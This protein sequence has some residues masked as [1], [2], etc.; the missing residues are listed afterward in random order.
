MNN[1]LTIKINLDK[2]TTEDLSFRYI[3]ADTIEERGIGTIVN[4]GTGEG[5]L[6]IGVMVNDVD[7]AKAQIKDLLASLNLEKN[8]EIEYD[9]E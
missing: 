1:Y 7:L 8:S 4:E 3:I 6:E 5:Y 2:I 9:E